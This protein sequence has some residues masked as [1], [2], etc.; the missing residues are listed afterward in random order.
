MSGSL[1]QKVLS[2]IAGRYNRP[3]INNIHR[4]E[5]V[6]HLVAA[7][8]G[9]EWFLPWT[10]GYDWAPWD[11]EHRPSGARME[12]KQSA[13]LQTWHTHEGIR[14]RSPRFDIA[15]RTGYWTSD[16]VWIDASGRPAHIYVFAWH[17]ETDPGLAD[18][19]AP[20]QWL[21]F[22]IP[23]ARLPASQKSIGL[24]G[25]RQFIEPVDFSALSATVDE[26]VR[27]RPA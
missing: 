13:A 21:F 5:Y 7:V 9:A 19:R 25:L 1:R 4:A 23:V 20:E 6:E 15:P 8:L 12:I 17:P 11:L 22:P 14:T 27:D 24:A 2:T 18:H 10:E 26:F 3:I 16:S